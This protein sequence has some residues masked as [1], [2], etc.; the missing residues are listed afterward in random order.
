MTYVFN[1]DRDEFVEFLDREVLPVV[2]FKTW[3]FGHYHR[4]T[5]FTIGGQINKHFTCLY[6]L[7]KEIDE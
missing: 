3:Y 6:N 4:N 1:E 2:D 5:E 7:I